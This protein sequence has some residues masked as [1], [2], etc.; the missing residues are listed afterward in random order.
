M[1]LWA[2]LLL[3]S[4]LPVWR[5]TSGKPAENFWSYAAYCFF[6]P[7][8]EHIPVEQAV[9]EARLAYCEYHGLDYEQSYT[10]H[11]EVPENSGIGL[12]PEM[13]VLVMSLPIF[14]SGLDKNLNGWEWAGHHWNERYSGIKVTHIPREDYLKAFE[15]GY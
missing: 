11:Y 2:A 13:T 6:T 10:E 3:A 12:L 5:V 7:D 14:R 8:R 15:Q 1:T 4:F 9:E